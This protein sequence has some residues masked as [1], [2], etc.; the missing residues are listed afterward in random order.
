MELEN[1]SSMIQ[2]SVVVVFFFFV[3]QKL[4]VDMGIFATYITNWST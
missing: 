4:I 2:D 3:S 1:V